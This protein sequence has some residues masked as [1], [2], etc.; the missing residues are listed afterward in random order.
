MSDDTK[1]PLRGVNGD[2]ALRMI[3][4]GTAAETGE[5]FFNAL[6]ESVAKA[7]NTKG[8]WVTEYL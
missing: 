6:V 4:E 2:S 7:L 8:A 1:L 5:R 3:M